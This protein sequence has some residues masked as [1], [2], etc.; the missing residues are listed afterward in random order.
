MNAINELQNTHVFIK[1]E[2]DALKLLDTTVESIKKYKAKK[3]LRAQ[4]NV[5]IPI[6]KIASNGDVENTNIF[7]RLKNRVAYSAGVCLNT[8]KDVVHTLT[9]SWVKKDILEKIN[10]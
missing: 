7:L 9:S 5:T 3:R 1:T 10:D 6:V 2:K 4:H 8:K